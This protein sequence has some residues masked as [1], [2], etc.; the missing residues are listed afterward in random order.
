MLARSTKERERAKKKTNEG[1][2]CEKA[3]ENTECDLKA[4]Q[5]CQTQ[6]KQQQQQQQQR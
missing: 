2:S 5:H 4:F 6:H 1:G 3:S